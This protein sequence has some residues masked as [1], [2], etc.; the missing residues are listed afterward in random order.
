MIATE[1][2]P[3]TYLLRVFN[4]GR[5]KI[6]HVGTKGDVVNYT[7]DNPGTLGIIDEDPDSSQPKEL[8]S[9]QIIEKTGSLTLMEKGN[10]SRLI[11]ISP[12]IEEWFYKRA[13]LLRIDPL[14]YDLPR[15][16]NELHSIFIIY[17]ITDV[18]CDSLGIHVCREPFKTWWYW[19]D[20][21]IELVENTEETKWYPPPRSVIAVFYERNN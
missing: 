19:A 1:C 7:R 11:K 15:D 14:T 12:R 21:E 9:Y 16:A 17:T 2:Y 10:S 3:D 13:S 20:G 18:R 5:K 6:R 8:N 4:V